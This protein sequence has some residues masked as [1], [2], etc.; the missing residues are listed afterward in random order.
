[1]RYFLLMLPIAALGLTACTGGDAAAPRTTS[2]S[3]ETF[4]SSGTY[5]TAE[6]SSRLIMLPGDS[7]SLAQMRYLSTH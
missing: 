4:I 3:Y 1:M 2:T 5:M 7:T 6:Q